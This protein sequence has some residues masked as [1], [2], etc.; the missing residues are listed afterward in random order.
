MMRKTTFLLLLGLAGFTSLF[1]QGPFS[2]EAPRLT[3][4]DSLFLSALPELHTMPV[5]KSN[6][7]PYALDN[8]RLKYYRP[9]YEQV[10]NE[11]GQVSGIAYN[12]TYEINRLRDLPADVPEN[13]YPPHFTY[14]FMNGGYGWYG[15]SYYHSFEILKTLGCPS[16]G[17][18]GGMA[19]GGESRWMDGYYNY[20]GAMSN[21]IREVYQI[22]A[23]TEEGLMQL[24]HWLHN[25]LDGSATGGVASFYANSPWNTTILPEGTPEAGQ[26]VITYWAG[27]P[28]HAMTITGYNDSIRYDYNSDG[29]YTN[30]IDLNM[31]GILDMRDW[32]IGGLV[33]ADGWQGGINFGDSGRCYM[34]Y[35]TLAEKLYEGG[36]WN[37]AV[38]ILDVKSLE[39]PRLAAKIR[40][41]H[42]RR[43]M[44]R[45]RL[46]V[47]ADEN[48]EE[49]EYSISFPVFNYQ[50]GMQYMQGG[51][52]PAENK[53]IE[54]GLD[55]TPLLG[56]NLSLPP[57]KF[58]LLVDERD[59]EGSG[60]GRIEYFSVIDYSQLYPIESS[61]EHTTMDI[62]DNNTTSAS[63]IISNDPEVMRITTADLPVAVVGE[64]YSFQLESSG[65][66]APVQWT[67]LHACSGEQFQSALG[68]AGTTIEAENND[69]GNIP[70][71]LPFSFPF[72]DEEYD[73]LY[74]HPRGLVMFENTNYPW[75]YL[76]D[77]E[78]LIRNTKCIAPLLAKY[79][80]IEPDSGHRMWV[81]Q[82]ADMVMIG[83]KGK[84]AD[85]AFEQD[86]EFGL[87]LY[88]D[89]KVEFIFGKGLEGY[90]TLWSCG[91]SK[92]D[93]QNYF[94]PSL[95]EN[96]TI[97]D[98][99]AVRITISPLP[100]DMQ[101]SPEGLFTGT[102]YTYYQALPLTFCAEDDDHCRSYRT[103]YFSA[104]DLGLDEAYLEDDLLSVYPN[105]FS[106]STS[107]RFEED[108]SIRSCKIYSMNGSLVRTLAT[109]QDLKIGQT[110]IW[111]GRN[112]EGESCPAGIYLLVTGNNER[113]IS[114]KLLYAGR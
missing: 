102:P 60:S 93:E 10:S 103:L 56:G 75:P 46:G 55:I 76:R 62:L 79:L 107:I 19:A 11:C 40:I 98:E 1:A 99:S 23:D 27:N 92:G 64:P 63:L 42:D 110:L 50:G 78:L 30:T 43:G 48:A 47:A 51:W 97:A 80:R 36:I 37:N 101:L 45:I 38:H 67:L 111:D 85:P 35:K 33:F 6:T 7:L 49:P 57:K 58:F 22:K 84:I 2:D 66:T 34:M 21:R 83:W 15:A 32:E 65:A 100:D 13:Q 16:V 68:Y 41:T 26:K 14:N 25:H 59:P 89:G 114:R 72:Y 87:Q 54:F 53:T 70:V 113:S 12:F 24:K 39:N 82:A 81:D 105:P 77:C 86:V 91:V 88:S 3:P 95:A 8:S 4:Y 96:E 74:V 106:E 20:L 94:I 5:M 9:I 112:E 109:E 28:T 104:G 17:T 44:L 52:S 90:K 18:Y 69:Y 31:D 61:W 108:I 73:T 29:K 71:S